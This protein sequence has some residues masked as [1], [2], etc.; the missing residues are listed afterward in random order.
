MSERIW[1]KFLTDRDRSLMRALDYD[2]EAGFGERPAL[3]VIDVTYSFCGAEPQP[4]LDAI[5][6]WRTSCGEDAWRAIPVIQSLIAKGREKGMPVIYTRNEFRDDGWDAGS[7]RWKASRRPPSGPGRN[8][9]HGNDILPA[10]APAP[11]DL[12]VR[13]QKPSGFFGTGLSSYLQLLGCDSVVV[14][15]GTTSGC[16]KATVLDAFS[17][18]YRVA[19]VEDACFDRLQAS[20]ALSLCD[21]HA[22]Y[23]DVV[24]SEKVLAILDTLQPG[25]FRLPGG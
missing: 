23:A 19:V 20:H 5:K 11:N 17:A 15:G 3:L 21:M 16:V 8:L 9:S 25:L 4:I 14:T 6:T 22:K 12:V 2:T 24:P 13:K 18:N 10:V 7:W 1:D